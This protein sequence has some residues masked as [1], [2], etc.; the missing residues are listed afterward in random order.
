MV[1]DPDLDSAAYVG[2]GPNNEPNVLGDGDDGIT[3]T[4][5]ASQLGG[6][7]V[8]ELMVPADLDGNGASPDSSPIGDYD[9]DGDV[10]T[11]DIVIVDSDLNGDGTDPVTSRWPRY[12]MRAAVRSRS[13]YS[14]RVL[15]LPNRCK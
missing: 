11:N 8:V 3:V 7:G 14:R 5:D 15:A 10:D 9:G 4:V 12:S 1:S 6:T 2:K 13:T